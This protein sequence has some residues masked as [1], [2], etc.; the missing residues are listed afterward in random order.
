LSEA[1]YVELRNLS[2]AKG[3]RSL[4]DFARITVQRAI[5]MPDGSSLGMEARFREL[6]DRTDE[7]DRELGRLMRLVERDGAGS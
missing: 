3:S 2:I 5:A 7:I 1:E 6:K 4:S